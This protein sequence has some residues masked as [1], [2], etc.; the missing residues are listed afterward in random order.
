[1]IFMVFTG[2]IHPYL[3]YPAYHAAPRSCLSCSFC[4]TNATSSHLRAFV[5]NLDLGVIFQDFYQGEDGRPTGLEPATFG[6]TIQRSNQLSYG[7]HT[8]KEVTLYLEIRISVNF[9]NLSTCCN[10]SLDHSLAINCKPRCL[11]NQPVNSSPFYCKKALR[12]NLEWGF[13]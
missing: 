8:E 6:T 7:R 2:Y 1:M 3:I 5:L 12:N 4:F 10:K 13:T 9:R 11:Y